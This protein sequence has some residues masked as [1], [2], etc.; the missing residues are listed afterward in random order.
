M[1]SHP[2]LQQHDH[3]HWFKAASPKEDGGDAKAKHH[4][5]GRS[6]LKIHFS[7]NQL[8]NL[9]KQIGQGSD[10][11]NNIIINNN[12]MP[13]SPPVRT[14]TPWMQSHL[15]LQQHDHH[16]WFKAP[17]PKEDGGDAKAK[18]HHQQR[19]HQ[20]H[21]QSRKNPV[22]ASAMRTGKFLQIRKVFATSSFLAEEFPGTLQYKIS[23]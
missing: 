18:H 9:D 1:R 17:S 16:H 2:K 13:P 22:S 8:Q 15:K 23:R 5:P 20:H 19:Y 10:K 12:K 11:N 21:R 3:H 14:R 6:V 4:S 7:F